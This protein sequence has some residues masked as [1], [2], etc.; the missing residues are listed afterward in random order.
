VGFLDLEEQ[1]R[2]NPDPGLALRLADLYRRQE[3]YDQAVRV[4]ERAVAR[5]PGHVQLTARLAAARGDAER[6]TPG[7]L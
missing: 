5:N 2:K 4:L 1:A 6:G 3:M 7:G